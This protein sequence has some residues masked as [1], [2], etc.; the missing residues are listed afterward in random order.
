[1]ILSEKHIRVAEKL[2]SYFERNLS[3]TG[4]HWKYPYD[5]SSEWLRLLK[6]DRPSL[7]DVAELKSKI[8]NPPEEQGSAFCELELMVNE[9]S[10]SL[11]HEE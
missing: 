2:V 9:W 7:A 4:E 5:V 8:Q 11:V 3:T 10:S 6:L 1:M